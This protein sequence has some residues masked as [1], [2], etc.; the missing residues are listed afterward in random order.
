MNKG[1]TIKW[2]LFS[3]LWGDLNHNRTPR[4]GVH[5]PV[6]KLDDT[7]I[8]A[9]PRKAKMLTSLPTPTNAL[10]YC[11]QL[12][13]QIQYNICAHDSIPPHLLSPKRKDH[14]LGWSFLFG[15]GGGNRTPVRK[16]FNR[17]FSGR[18][19]SF[20]FPHPSAGRHARGFGSFM[21]RGTGKAYRTH[22]PHSST[23]HP[24]SW[25]SRAERSLFKQ[26]EEQCYRC[27]LIYKS[28]PFYGW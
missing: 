24:G 3:S 8:F 5:R 19:R 23:L 9:V 11:L 17:N 16:Y 7:L 14:P 12:S 28:C 21:M 13:K 18:R 1:T 2:F 20:A 4:W 15:G 6:Q 27:S 22:V 25:A 10:A 26:R